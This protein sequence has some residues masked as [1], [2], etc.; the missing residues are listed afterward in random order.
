[1]SSALDEAESHRQDPSRDRG[2]APQKLP[3]ELGTS[4]FIDDFVDRKRLSIG[5]G[6]RERD[7]VVAV[8]SEHEVQVELIV[9]GLFCPVAIAATTHK[10]IE[11]LEPSV[12]I[13]R[14]VHFLTELLRSPSMG[15]VERHVERIVKI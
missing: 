9:L 2:Q 3:G 12:S 10:F 11:F 6:L 4:T 13:V 7:G 8:L 1:M 5:N 15:Y 14:E